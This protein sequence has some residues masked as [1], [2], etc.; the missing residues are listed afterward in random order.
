MPNAAKTAALAFLLAAC[1]K[2]PSDQNIVVDN[3]IPA[4]AEIETLP[5]DESDVTSSNELVNGDDSPDVNDLNTAS[6]QD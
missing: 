2:Q 5:P 3:G 4:N 1:S 6:N